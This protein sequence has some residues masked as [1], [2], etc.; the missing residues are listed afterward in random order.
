VRFELDDGRALAEE[1]AV[2]VLA[3]ELDARHRAGHAEQVAQRRHVDDGHEEE[4]V[5]HDRERHEP[6]HQRPARHTVNCI[7]VEEFSHT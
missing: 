7:P 1:R 6:R 2:V 5:E 4:A 3:D